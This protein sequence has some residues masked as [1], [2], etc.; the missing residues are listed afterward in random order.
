MRTAK[1]A[2]TALVKAGIIV[3]RDGKGTPEDSIVVAP[4]VT[5]LH[6]AFL[7]LLAGDDDDGEE[8]P[9]AVEAVEPVEDEETPET[10]EAVEAP[11]KRP[12]VKATIAAIKAIRDDAPVG[13]DDAAATALFAAFADDERGGVVKAIAAAV[14]AIVKAGA[15]VPEPTAGEIAA[16]VAAE[17]KR[18]LR[19]ARAAYEC[20]S[21]TDMTPRDE[22]GA[23]VALCP[24]CGT[25]AEGE[26]EIDSVFGIRQMKA[27]RDAAGTFKLTIR[28]QSYCKSCRSKHAKARRLAGL[29][30]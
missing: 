21:T 28:V 30:A 1:A 17:A 5:A 20:V 9:E 25:V 15:P 10:P 4:A 18:A 22:D 29:S 26:A 19:E 3:S 12:T 2:I 11:P 7:S 8:T 23:A 27:F 6:E 13:M 16:A 14:K 24:S